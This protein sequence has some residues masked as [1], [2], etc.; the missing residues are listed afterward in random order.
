VGLLLK[1]SSS[2]L[3]RNPGWKPTLPGAKSGHFT[4]ADLINFVGDVNPIGNK[5]GG[6]N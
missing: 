4:M 5:P 3:S 6:G 1:D 2:F